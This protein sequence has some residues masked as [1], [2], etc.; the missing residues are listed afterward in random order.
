MKSTKYILFILLIAFIGSAI[1]IAVQPNDFSFSKTKTIEAPQ[2]VIYNYVSDL[3]HWSS[4]APWK[5]MSTS[6]SILNSKEY[7]WLE[8]NAIGRITTTSSSKPSTIHQDI[9]FSEYPKSQLDWKIDSTSSKASTVTLTMSS[10][11]IPFKKK[12][13]YAFFGTPEEELAPKFETSLT[14]LDSAISAS[15]KVYSITINGIT[16]HSG[17]YYLYNT[18][19]SKIDNYQEKVQ[20]MMPE[21]TNYVTE[22]HIAMAGFPFV[23][24]HKW[25]KEN[26]AVIF[27][28]CVPTSTQVITT[29]PNILTGMLPAF[30]TLKTTLKGD[31]DYLDKAWDLTFQHLNTNSLEQAK[32]NIMLETFV[33]NPKYKINPADWI[34]EIYVALE[35]DSDTIPLELKNLK[36]PLDDN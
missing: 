4:W 26:N 2:E 34:T 13:Y 22:N 29:N 36:L 1:Y 7:T 24:Y 27:S 12:A 18:T 6:D 10:K 3:N 33:T 15:M 8:D 23:L 32:S 35:E 31:Y 16:N 28:C 11:N 14:Q 19:S 30:K 21:I 20:A 25:D 5:K 9:I 17:G